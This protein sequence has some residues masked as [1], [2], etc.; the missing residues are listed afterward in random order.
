MSS[1]TL[2]LVNLKY[3]SEGVGGGSMSLQLAVD[4]IHQT[5]SGQARGKIQ[6]GT[7]H[8]PSFTASCQ[9]TMHSTG[10]GDVVNIGAVH[11]RA[12]VSAP[13][14]LIGTYLAPFTAEF[15]VDGKWSGK[16]KFS[17]G[18]NTYQCTVERD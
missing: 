9:G 6:E 16:G 2:Y 10:Y 3:A 18:G 4:P 12:A 7:E 5:L 13:P 8:S 17:V 1:D 15:A 11:G 14:P